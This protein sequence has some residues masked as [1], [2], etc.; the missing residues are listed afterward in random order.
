MKFKYEKSCIQIFARE[1]VRGRVKTR[2]NEF[3]G[4]ERTL[5]LYQ[6]LLKRVLRQVVDAALA[7]VELWVDGN[8]RHPLFAD[9]LPAQQC[10]AQQGPD[11][12]QRMAFAARQGLAR[13]DSLL[14]IGTDCPGLGADYLDRALDSLRND[15]TVVFGPAEDGGYVLLG[16]NAF[17]AG[18]FEGIPWG[19]NRVLE[20]SLAALEGGGQHV[21]LMDTL[22]DVDRPEDLARLNNLSPPLPY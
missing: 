1:P 22:W 17:A 15:A 12:G 8:P 11:L 7:P 5:V 4:V 3:L 20:S 16:L 19:G 18:L 14:L 2:L 21:V 6:N 10:L 13:Y 9:C